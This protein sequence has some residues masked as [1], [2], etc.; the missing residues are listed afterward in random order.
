M[1]EEEVK[2]LADQALKADKIITEQLF[3]WKW[4][5]PDIHALQ[6]VTLTPSIADLTI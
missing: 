3:G 1:H 6:Q 2:D 5:A 4:K